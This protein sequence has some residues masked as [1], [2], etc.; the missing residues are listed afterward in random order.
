LYSFT[1]TE[2]EA[3]KNSPFESVKKI[4]T[5][6]QDNAKVITPFTNNAFYQ[7]YSAID[8]TTSKRWFA[9]VPELT[10][11]LF[12]SGT[13]DPVGSYG[14][15]AED[16]K[17]YLGNQKNKKVALLKGAAH[18]LYGKELRE[19]LLSAIKNFLNEYGG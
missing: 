4:W 17:K 16:I 1:K 11:I 5:L 18:Q 12:I 13:K 2:K 10:P 15:F 14:K 3:K 19:D 9:H 7:L 8:F 6:Y